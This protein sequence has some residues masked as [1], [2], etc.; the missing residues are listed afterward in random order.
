MEIMRVVEPREEKSIKLNR[1]Y[2]KSSNMPIVSNI[3]KTFRE[4]HVYTSEYMVSM[5]L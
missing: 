5:P 2:I 3:V 4:Q 1:R